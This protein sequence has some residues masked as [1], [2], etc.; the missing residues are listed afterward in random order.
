MKITAV[1]TIQCADFANL[2]WLRLYTDQGLVG[3]GET[4]RNPE[5]VVAYVHETCAPYLLGKDPR[6]ID[7]HHDA[8]QHRV[9]SHFDGFPTRSIEIRGNSAVDIA[10]WDL[11]GQALGQ[12]VA[13]LLGG[14]TRERIRV[15]NT[16]AGYSYNTK[17]L[18]HYNTE[19][20][21]RTG[22][23]AAARPYE[24]LEA[25]IHRPAELAQ[26]LLAEGITGMKIWPFDQAAIA[27][28]GHA[29]A[30]ADLAAGLRPIEA[31]RKAVGDRMDI[32]IE[33][34][35]LWHLPVA[36]EIARAADEYGV[37][38]HE[39]P[40]AMQNFA[41]LAEFK[42]RV[43]GR[44]GGSE[45]LGTRAWYREVFQR[46]AVDVVH[47][48]MGWI[49][50]LTEGKRIAALADTYDRPIAPHDCTGPVQLA[51]NVH[52]MMNVVNTLIAETVRAYYRGYYGEI[53]T[54]LPEVKDG[55]IHA[56]TGPGLGTALSDEFLARPDL[57]IRRSD[58]ESI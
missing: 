30:P 20:A 7:R 24:D 25:Q 37:F 47:F 49:G 2:V 31:I 6:Q 43:K 10:L 36:L 51:A 9:G 34:H 21:S 41:D 29:I 58:A 14:F 15:Y 5:A 22:S 53:V 18:T 54:T 3:L 40:I 42:R 52:L 35:G 27:G 38:W 12:P 26:S 32:M 4:I 8:L 46:G 13:Q 23:V 28:G 56:L 50:G 55:F 45:N 48:D 57:A 39:D 16:C 17:A 1:E 44:V 11:L 33:Y 19:L